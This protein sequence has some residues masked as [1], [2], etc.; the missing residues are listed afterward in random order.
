[1]EVLKDPVL[2]A[3]QVL[4]VLLGQRAQQKQREDLVVEC[5]AIH[6]AVAQ[7]YPI[8]VVPR[9]RLARRVLGLP[10][11]SSSSSFSLLPDQHLL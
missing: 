6:S 9:A 10:S 11:F 4:L 2:E 8:A 1:M 3:M 7:F 5:F